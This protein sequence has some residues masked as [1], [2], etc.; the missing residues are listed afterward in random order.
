MAE[1]EKLTLWR[2]VLNG[3]HGEWN[4]NDP[5]Q[6][7]EDYL[8]PA[9]TIETID[10]VPASRVTLLEDGLRA[11]VAILR[12]VEKAAGE[13]EQGRI[14]RFATELGDRLEAL[15][16]QQEEEAQGG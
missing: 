1:Q 16:N 14:H 5:P 10:V 11:E 4:V 13:S 9:S 15:L 3:A 6:R 8:F 2:Y 7:P 12:Q